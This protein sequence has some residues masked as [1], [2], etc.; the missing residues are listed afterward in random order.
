MSTKE[1]TR[2]TAPQA[3]GR[4]DKPAPVVHKFVELIPSGT[5][6]DFVGMRGRML[7]FSW[8]LIL[9]SL[10]FTHFVRGGLRLGIDF[11]GGTMVHVKFAERTSIGD[12]RAA[13][14]K[15]ELGEVI[16]QDVGRDSREFQIRLLGGEGGQG[17]TSV[18]AAI[19]KGLQEKFGEG[20][21]DVLRVET[22]GPKVG[23]DL[24]WDAF[25]AVLFATVVMGVYIAFRFEVRFGIG[26]A[27]ALVHDV[28]LTLGALGVFQME[29]DLT[30]VAALL[31]VVGYSV[32]D[33]V[34]VSDR[35]REN[36]RKMRRDTLATIMNLS[37]NET[38]SRTLITS[39][40]A[41]LVTLVLF[42]FGG[43]VIHSF[44]FTLLVGFIVGT[45]SSIYVASPVVLYLEGR[46]RAR[47]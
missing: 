47:R 40:T 10:A 32:H 14:S 30:T 38:L 26:A 7:V 41:I 9:A 5:K 22:V 36:M 6:V 17:A 25:W 2:P 31:T 19:K 8:A 24:W 20:T 18:A 44:A 29:F 13:L 16:V 21:Y 11:A 42:L 23:K 28:L 45:Y 37:I 4:R 39:G 46:T 12:I 15:P 34:I 1:G 27:I 33:T 3:P 35:I 43:S